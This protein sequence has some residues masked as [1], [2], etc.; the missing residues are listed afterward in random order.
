V[1]RIDGGIYGIRMP[2]KPRETLAEFFKR[3]TEGKKRPQWK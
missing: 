3:K 2:K 1:A